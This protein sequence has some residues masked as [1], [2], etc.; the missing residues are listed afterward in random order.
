MLLAALVVFVGFWG[1]LAISKHQKLFFGALAATLLVECA[2]LLMYLHGAYAL[3]RGAIYFQPPEPWRQPVTLVVT[4]ASGAL[5]PGQCEISNNHGNPVYGLKY[6]IRHPRG[7]ETSTLNLGAGVTP[8]NLPS[9]LR[10]MDA[11]GVTAQAKS[12]PTEPPGDPK[13]GACIDHFV[14]ALDTDEARAFRSLFAA[15]PT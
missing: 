8:T 4:R 7:E 5:G 10:G 14:S 13:F 11:S 3:R 1:L 9:W 15:G 6:E 12:V 2:L